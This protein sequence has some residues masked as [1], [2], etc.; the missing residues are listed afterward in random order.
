M[1]LVIVLPSQWFQQ[2]NRDNLMTRFNL[3]NNKLRFNSSQ[4]SLR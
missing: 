2:K 3:Y 4:T 1:E